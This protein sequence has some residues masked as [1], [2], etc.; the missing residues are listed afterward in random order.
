MPRVACPVHGPTVIAVP[1]ARHGARHT[2]DFDAQVAWLV[3]NS[4]KAAV[5]ELARTAWETVGSII[6]RVMADADAVAGDRLANLR[7]VGIDEVAY[8]RGHKYL[9]EVVDHA[10]GRLL[11]VGK[12]RDKKTLAAFFDLLGDDRCRRIALVSADGADWIADLV[13]LRCPNARL[14]MDPFHV[15]KWVNDALDQTRRRVW[16]HA[17]QSGYKALSKELKHA[18]FALVK[19]PDDLTERQAVKLAR[20]REVN[21]HLYRAYLMKEQLR[22]VFAPGDENRIEMLDE[23][24]AWASRCRIPEF[25]ELARK[26]RRYRGDIANTLTHQLTNGPVEGINSRIRTII[27]IAHGFRDIDALMALIRLHLGGYHTTLPG[28]QPATP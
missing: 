11:W 20:I 21:N 13:A 2:V 18:R 26:M 24:L 3:R 19:N 15:V 1:W 12:G 17:Q 28:R 8:A 4:S 25:V 14:C 16:R 27:N 10:T 6:A 9:V 7:R 22:Q 23:W 5:A